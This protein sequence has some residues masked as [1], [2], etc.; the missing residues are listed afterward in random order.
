MV[1]MHARWP[2]SPN[3]GATRRLGDSH[4]GDAPST[5]CGAGSTSAAPASGSHFLLTRH[6][7]RSPILAR[8]Q[9][10]GASVLN[11]LLPVP[12]HSQMLTEGEF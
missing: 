9:R 1:V 10:I 6:D 5:I 3:A 12:I 7:K 2:V 8:Q 11:K 4:F